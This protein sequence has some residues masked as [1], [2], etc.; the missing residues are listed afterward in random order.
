MSDDNVGM[1]LFEIRHTWAWYR[2]VVLKETDQTWMTSKGRKI[3]GKS[4]VLV[5][6][7]VNPKKAE[8]AFAAAIRRHEGAV[9]EAQD[10]LASAQHE[11][12]LAAIRALKGEQ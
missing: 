12:R 11:Q 2:G 8:E 3:K 4:D 9:K 7:V 5:S 6:G 1:H 10:A